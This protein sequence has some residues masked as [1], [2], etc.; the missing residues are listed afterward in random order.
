MRSEKVEDILRGILGAGFETWDWW[1][2]VEYSTG[3]DWDTYPEDS[4][5][6]FITLAIQDQDEWDAATQER[7][8]SVD[9]ILRA[10]LEI[11]GQWRGQRFLDQEDAVSSDAVLQKAVLGAIVYG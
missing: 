1:Q 2:K 10:Y 7:T 9:D 11:Q 4:T 8:L 6:P 3:F 5:E